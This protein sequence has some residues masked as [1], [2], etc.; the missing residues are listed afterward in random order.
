MQT[1]IPVD[2][3]RQI[4]AKKMI[5]VMW[6]QKPGDVEELRKLGQQAKQ[7]GYDDL[8]KHAEEIARAFE[9][10]DIHALIMSFLGG[11]S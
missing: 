6:E 4:L 10:D 11:E 7:R 8:A 1:Q 3:F 9:T 5:T 2:N